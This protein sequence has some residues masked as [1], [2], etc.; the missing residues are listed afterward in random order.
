MSVVSI[1]LVSCYVRENCRKVSQGDFS[2]TLPPKRVTPSPALCCE[3]AVSSSLRTWP[4]AASQVL[5]KRSVEPA[6]WP[7]EDLPS[8]GCLLWTSWDQGHCS[9][10][11]EVCVY[12]QS[13]KIFLKRN[14][15]SSRTSIERFEKRLKFP[16]GSVFPVKSRPS[17]PHLSSCFS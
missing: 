2:V 3:A 13:K 1:C 16:L 17:L 7:C 6:R 11:Q 12:F 9:R 15:S 5:C 8:E 4:S 10:P 14:S